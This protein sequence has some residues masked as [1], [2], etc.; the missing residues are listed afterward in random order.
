LND[1]EEEETKHFKSKG[2]ARALDSTATTLL[3]TRHTRAPELSDRMVSD[4]DLPGLPPPLTAAEFLK[5][6]SADPP[7]V[8]LL[9]S[10]NRHITVH[11]QQRRAI[12]LI[13]G[14]IAEGDGLDGKSMAIVGAGFAGLTAAAFTLEKTTVEVSLFEVATRPL[15]LQDGS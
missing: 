12:N 5:W 2:I 15:W 8:Y 13:R 10:L 6:M 1:E 11:S 4:N 7:G 3:P 9:G 14:L